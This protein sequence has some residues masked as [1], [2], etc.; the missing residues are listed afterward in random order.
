MPES[1]DDLEDAARA[2]TLTET[3]TFDGKSELPTPKKNRDLAEDICAMTVDGGV[4]I[5]G[6]G[7]D[8]DKRLTVLKP[9]GL[10]GSRERIDQVA[11]TAISEPPQ[12]RTIALE[13]PDDPARGYIVAQVPPSP[14]APHQVTVGK[15][16]RYYGRGDTG[17]R[18]L[19]ES[20]IAALYSRRQS[21]EVSRDELLKAAVGRAPIG[22][23]HGLAYLHAYVRPVA[24]DRTLLARA[25]SGDDQELRSRLLAGRDRAAGKAHAYDPDLRGVF[26]WTNRGAEG[27]VLADEFERRAG[28]RVQV[29][30]DRDGSGWL[31]C[32]RAGEQYRE[33]E[34]IRLFEELVAGNLSAFFGMLGELYGAAGYVGPVDVGVALTG[35]AAAV[36]GTMGRQ[37][38]QVAFGHDEYRET[39]RIG[40]AASLCER[41]R[42]ISRGLLQPLF[43]VVS[44]IGFDPY[45]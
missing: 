16:R 35:T 24:A 7:E 6:V 5:Y 18:I 23:V 26:Y 14:R 27:W 10:A 43:D 12:I 32:A 44:P 45:A 39:D 41:P 25:A 29:G 3:H 36:S 21:W 11:H 19:A 13:L 40:W 17:N 4:L 28:R 42:E 20:E 31:F 34:P 37:F 30:I 9:L 2:G 1:V 15:D 22:H 38:R 33:N 8:A